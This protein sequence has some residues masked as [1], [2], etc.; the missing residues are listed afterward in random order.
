M[1]SILDRSCPPSFQVPHSRGSSESADIAP[2]A[3]HPSLSNF[4]LDGHFST[5]LTIGT[6]SRTAVHLI[7]FLDL[8]LLSSF[9][10][11]QALPTHRHAPSM[12]LSRRL[13]LPQVRRAAAEQPPAATVL[14]YSSPQHYLH[15]RRL[16]AGRVSSSP[17]SV[18]AEGQH[19]HE[20]DARHLPAQLTTV[21]HI[22]LTR[23]RHHYDD[24]GEEQDDDDADDEDDER[25]SGSG[26]GRG[27]GSKKGKGKQK[28]KDANGYD[29]GSWRGDQ[30]D[31][32][33]SSSDSWE[34]EK[35]KVKSVKSSSSSKKDAK[36]DDEEEE[37][38]DE[39]DE[40]ETFAPKAKVKAVKGTKA[41]SEIDEASE[42]PN[43]EEDSTATD[44]AET[45]TAKPTAKVK[46]VQSSKGADDEPTATE[47][48]D[49]PSSTASSTKKARSSAIPARSGAGSSGSSGADCE[50]L[51]AVYEDMGG[52]DWVTQDGWGDKDGS[53]C[54]SAYGVSCNSEGRVTA[55]D[56]KNNGLTGALSAHVFD[57]AALYRL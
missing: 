2:A 36:G 28:G 42:D 13:R 20:L 1:L 57:L 19:P 17:R 15:R 35:G 26:S 55:L 27:R 9:Y 10:V 29:D 11:V 22:I 53:S 33:G 4:R 43:P 31:Y 5:M 44:D 30:G 6:S 41:G 23:R 45:T 52:A 46:A 18:A 51:T 21:Q 24:D 25:E 37:T 50:T 16:R 32:G 40:E 34:E 12:H 39:E 8:L 14:E 38:V 48:E 54:C 47:D 7:L 56:L 3:R 49:E